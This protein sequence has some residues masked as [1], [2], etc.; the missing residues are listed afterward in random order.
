[1]DK[2]INFNIAR[3]ESEL[4]R[5]RQGLT[6]LDKISPHSV[7]DL[8]TDYYEKLTEEYKN[9]ADA[10]LAEYHRFQNTNKEEI[11]KH[12][13]SDYSELFLSFSTNNSD[14]MFPGILQHYRYGINPV[15]AIYYEM[16]TLCAHPERNEN[17][18]DWLEDLLTTPEFNKKIVTALEQDI[19]RLKHVVVTYFQ[20]LRISDELIP[21]ELYHAKRKIEEFSRCCAYFKEVL[22]IGCGATRKH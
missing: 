3:I 12:L 9:I 6:S 14:F 18:H 19:K 5:Y 22:R 16:Q 8:K 2:V 11:I 1:M 15:V 7:G 21:L 13:K 4:D 20:A 17:M 10:F